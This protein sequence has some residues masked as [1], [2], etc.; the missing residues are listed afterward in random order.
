M[1]TTTRRADYSRQDGFSLANSDSFSRKFWKNTVASVAIFAGASLAS[2]VSSNG[3]PL[4]TFFDT[5]A[6][7]AV[8]SRAFNG[9]VRHKLGDGTFAP[10]TF[11]FGKGGE[12]SF[13]N[14][15]DRSLDDLRFPEIARLLAAPL[16]KRK[17][18]SSPD[19]KATQLLIMVYW[20]RTLGGENTTDGA[21]QDG[22]NYFNAHLL[23]YEDQMRFLGETSGAFMLGHILREV[24]SADVS[25]IGANRYYVILRAFDFQAAWNQK[26]LVILWETRFSLAERRHGFDQDL[27]MMAAAASRYFGQDT[28]GLVRPQVR[29]GEVTIGEVTSLD[30]PDAGP[31]VNASQLSGEWQGSVNGAPAVKI[32]VDSSGAT[33][34]ENSQHQTV[35]PARISLEDNRVILTVPGWNILF[36]G[37]LEGDRIS[38]R[39]SQYGSEG[40]LILTKKSSGAQP[41][42]TS[43][44]H[45]ENR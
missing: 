18:V 41:T 43:V 35:L 34:F 28:H 36:R 20:G 6:T 22:L 12:L 19:P 29:E 23:G 30:D 13:A 11:A 9:Y 45:L 7:T 27:P 8:N 25:E 1:N 26:K 40:Q 38:G 21:A 24:H 31:G 4:Q 37:R 10:E 42:T 39:L 32:H 17:Y 15:R 14:L 33:V 2:A 44:R 5:D 16:A 3:G